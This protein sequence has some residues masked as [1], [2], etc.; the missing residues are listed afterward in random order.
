MKRTFLFLLWLITNSCGVI[1]KS[2]ASIYFAGQI[3]NPTSPYVVLY[4]DDQII[5]SARLDKQ[6][7]FKINFKTN[8]EGLYHFD[9]NPQFHYVY[10]EKGDSLTLRLNT[11]DFDESMAFSGKGEEINNF[12]VEL[13]LANEEDEKII[14]QYFQL[15]PK[16]FNEKIETLRKSKINQLSSLLEEV[17]LSDRATALINATIDYNAFIYKEKYPFYHKIAAHEETLHNLPNNF[18]D[19]RKN[20]SLNNKD[21][22]YFRPYYNFMKYH[23]G[24]LAYMQ[25]NKQCG[26]EISNSDA[27]HF[28]KHKLKLIDSLIQEKKLKDNLYR[29]VVIHYLLKIKDS[30]ENTE[31]F[32]TFFRQYNPNNSHMQEITSLYKDISNLQ[33]NNKLPAVVLINTNGNP[34]NL[35]SIAQNKRA[36]FYFWSGQYETHFTNIQKQLLLLTKQYPEF[37][38]IGINTDTEYNEWQKII[39]TQG[40]IKENQF[41]SEDY[42]LL[43]N[44]LVI[45]HLNKAI[46][47]NKGVIVNAFADLYNLKN[48]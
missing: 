11:V 37:T 8:T 19:Y 3:V 2:P 33:P 23:L 34:I 41:R 17:N 45:D 16:L 36:V 13:F 14:D 26:Q 27:V 39:L 1:D 18:Y 46:I 32:I 6:N 21:L 4:K 47:T 43:K 9:H 7:R 40:L 10:L 15:E 42:E 38:F 35:T 5:D 31:R 20:L 25:C 12:I 30:P 44:T 24:N 29:N 48:Q 22:I 28:N